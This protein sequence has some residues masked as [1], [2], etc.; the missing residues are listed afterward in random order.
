MEDLSTVLPFESKIVVIE[1]T[2]DKLLEALEHSVHRYTDGE[3]RGEFLQYSG[4]YVEYDMNQPPEKRVVNVK[5]LCGYCE[6]PMLENINLAKKYRIVVQDFL[7]NG[8]DGYSMFKDSQLYESEAI[9]VEVLKEFVKKKSPI[10]P[11]NEWRISIKDYVDPSEDI[12]GSTRVFLD[13][14]C[15]RG[16]CNL[17]NFIADAMINWYSVNNEVTS[18]WTGASIALIPAYNIKH[19]IDNKLNDG[20]IT[21]KDASDTLPLNNKIVIAN[22]TGKTLL[23]VL[24]YAIHRYDQ[25]IQPPEFLQISGMQ[26]EYDVTKKIGNRLKSTKVLCSSCTVPQLEEVDPN[27]SYNVLI[28]ENIGTGM[29]GYSMLKDNIHETFNITETDVFINYLKRKSPVYPAVEWRITLNQ[30]DSLQDIVGVT[31]VLLSNDCALQECNFGNFIADSMV[32]WY[33]LNYNGS[34][35]SDAS[36]AIV[37]GSTIKSQINSTNA[38]GNIYRNDV[39]KVFDPPYNLQL[40]T[41]KGSD[42]INL[43]EYSVSTYGDVNYLDFL[44]LSG[45]QVSY[46][47]N[48]PS[49]NRIT[50]IKVLCSK[51][52]VPELQSVNKTEDYKLIVQSSLISNDYHEVILGSEIQD[53]DETDINVFLQYLKKKSPIYPAVEWRITINEKNE[54]EITSTLPPPTTLSASNAHIHLY[55]IIISGL[56]T[57]FY[58]NA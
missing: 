33:S 32:D 34:G 57:I 24:E 49:G 11:G 16:E 45:I 1:I 13:G 7:A 43:L 19:S 52:N 30:F 47:L 29:L 28:P 5:V 54:E 25:G 39:E 15:Y 4:L 31:R 9:D 10:Y 14:K 56:L 42:L 27:T 18:G 41:L 2:G 50:D 35:W 51:C 40:L 48:E 23:D 37:L 22:V 36:I 17:G 21:R 53:L 6:V 55:L 38:G 46:D 8:G 44:Q 58:N 26:I 20:V 3:E 12:I